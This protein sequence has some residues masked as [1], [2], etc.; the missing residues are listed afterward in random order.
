[1]RWYLSYVAKLINTVIIYNVCKNAWTEE[2]TLYGECQFH[3]SML[4]AD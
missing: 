2:L 3:A 1:M 4:S